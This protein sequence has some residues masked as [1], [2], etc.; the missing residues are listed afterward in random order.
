MTDKISLLN[1]W[2]PEKQ[3]KVMFKNI[4]SNWYF[5]FSAMAFFLLNAPLSFSYLLGLPIAFLATIVIASQI[6]SIWNYTKENSVCL[7]VLS[8]L[9]AVGICL[10]VQELFY[11]IWSDSS[12]VKALK[13]ALHI[14]IDLP[15]VASIIFAVLGLFFVY[16]CI[17]IFYKCII[18]IFAELK[19]FSGIKTAEW[20]V[21][22]LLILISLGL[23]VFSFSQSE[24]FYGTDFECDIIYTSDSPSLVKGNVYLVLTHPENDLRQPLF[25]LFSAPFTGV[26][27]LFAKLIGASESVR[28]MV[29][30][31]VQIFMLFAANFI[32]S[33]IMK[34]DFI[35]RI[36][37]MVLAWSTYM[38]LLFTVMMEQY[39][40][41]YF[42][43]ILCIYFIAEKKQPNRLVL[44]GAGGTLLISMGLLPFTSNNSPIKKFKAWLTDMVV[45]GVEFVSLILIF[46]RFDVIYNFLSSIIFL[47]R[48]TGKNLTFADK[49][50]QYTELVSNCFTAPK[51]GVNRDAFE[52]ISWQLKTATGINIVGVSI[53]LLVVISAILNRKNRSSLL[54]IGWVGFSV[55]ML[56][57][58][59]WGTEEN[60]LILYSLYFGWAFLVLLFQLLEKV[61]NKLKVRFLIPVL[62]VGATIVLL[63]INIPAFFEMVKF[64]IAHYP[65]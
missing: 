37:F 36:C 7:R 60:G 50:Y 40:V 48:F 29:L 15:A 2:F 53:L 26:F 49:I 1:Q 43:L 28:A 14:N 58:L 11:S 44:C 39:I 35:K 34:L 25:S 41:A 62:T 42:W 13:S 9:T 4:V 64:A 46:C 32:L 54:S 12:K 20:F 65:L 30:N 59:G 16:F 63:M 38:Q 24:A 19:I 21:Y 55:V 3:K 18:E 27:Y 8:I 22:G 17:L 57:I 47:S 23:M 56:L 45:H 61:E 6:P 33:K 52:Y 51:A 5:P 31:S 10:G